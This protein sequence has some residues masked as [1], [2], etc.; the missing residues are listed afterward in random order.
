LRGTVLVLVLVFISAS[1][2][3]APAIGQYTVGST[4]TVVY[5]AG[6]P[7][8]YV[9]GNKIRNATSP[10][11]L[12][13]CNVRGQAFNPATS[14]K[15]DDWYTDRFLDAANIE[16]YEFNTIRLVTH[17][18]RIETSQ[19][20]ADFSYNDSYIELI[21]QT[22]EAYNAKGIYVIVNLHTHSSVN[23]LARFVPTLGNDGDFSDS[24]YSDV[25]NTSAR[26][27]LKRL[28]LR[29]SETFKDYAGFAGYDILNEPHRSTGS[30]S[31]QE[32]A[33]L[34]F[35]MADY[36]IQALRANSDTHIVFVNFAPWARNTGFMT[37][38]LGDVNVV[39]EPHFY[40]GINEADLSVSNND[41]AWLQQQFNT[42]VDAKMRQFNVPYIMGEQG[43]GSNQINSGDSRDIWLRNVLSIHKQS[44][45]MQ[46][47]SYFCYISYDGVVQGGGWQSTLTEYLP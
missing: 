3:R 6:L 1:F 7:S 30:L 38:K 29:M 16:T 15:Y 12:L 33:D 5:P 25:S 22:V 17:W 44:P 14:G 24:F 10:V 37:R 42:Y 13:G 23:D 41:Y 31:N 20:P 2:V 9:D 39:Y 36:V 27:H 35:D 32:V 45:L 46:G 47:W 4:G 43:F 8:L 21:R 11:F 34:W 19:N 26:E 40:F 18:E 28:W